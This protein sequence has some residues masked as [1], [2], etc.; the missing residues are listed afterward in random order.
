MD[1]QDPI[2]DCGTERAEQP[3]QV[4]SLTDPFS[5]TPSEHIA[6]L[7]SLVLP[8]RVPSTP[9]LMMIYNVSADLRPRLVF[10]EVRC[11]SHYVAPFHQ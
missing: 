6:A 10:I 3:Q 1:L 5:P 8:R 11:V 2:A 4:L 7:A 9:L